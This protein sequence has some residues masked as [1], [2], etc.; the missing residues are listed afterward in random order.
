MGGAGMSVALRASSTAQPTP[1]TT[2]PAT[3]LRLS[4]HLHRNPGLAV[5]CLPAFMM[6]LAPPTHVH[7]PLRALR[8]WSLVGGA[9]RQCRCIVA[10]VSGGVGHLVT[11]TKGGRK[12]VEMV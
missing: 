1:L 12:A 4:S 8:A 3:A 11:Y 5:P 6:S 9:W 10:L 2:A 7:Y